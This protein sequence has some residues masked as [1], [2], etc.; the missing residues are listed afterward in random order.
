MGKYLSF[1]V[2]ESFTYKMGL[3]KQKLGFHIKGPMGYLKTVRMCGQ[4]LM[5]HDYQMD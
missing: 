5:G 2:K 3:D 4:F 1:Y